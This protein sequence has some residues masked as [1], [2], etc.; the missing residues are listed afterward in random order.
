MLALA[1]DERFAAQIEAREDFYFFTRYLFLERRNFKW[2]RAPHHRILCDKLQSVLDGK[3]KRLI[4]NIPPRYSK[5][6]LLINFMAYGLGH[7]PD[8]EF[9]YTSY[10]SSL[11]T[12]STWEC[13]EI[14]A[15]PEFESIFPGV[16][17]NQD[18]KARD[19][20]RT[21]QTGLVYGVGAGGTITGYGA[22]K[23]RDGFG[24]AIVIDDPHKPDEARSDTIRNNVIEW[25][26]NTLE[27]RKNSPDTPV[28]LI[29]Q[30]LHEE[31]LSGFLLAGGNGETWEHLCL[32][33]ITEDGEALW[34]HKHD[35]ETLRTMRQASPY[36]FAG[37]YMQSPA[38]PE[39]NIFRPDQM[40]II[41][42]LPAG[43]NLSVRGWDLGSA[44]DGDY[45]VGAKIVKLPGGRYVIADIARFRRGPDERDT[46]MLNTAK[47][48]G[49]GTRIDLPQDPGQAGKS[50]VQYLVKMLKGFRV[51][52]SPE[53]GDK[54]TRAEPLAAQVNVGNVSLLSGDWNRGLIEEM[55]MF[56]NG[57]H[58][59][60]VDALSRAFNS[61]IGRGGL[62]ITD[63][64]L[65]QI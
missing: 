14:V 39:G 56:P 28:I 43:S 51:N 57:A 48:D 50:Q 1:N 58:D 24:G 27:S 34:E 49:H 55:R 17:I 8:S 20:W 40:P 65:R 25:F 52:T 62:S 33:A 35:I 45:T 11:A 31:D 44:L 47:L 18:A 32:P 26:R 63:E 23:L 37:Q 16:K 64:M 41:D 42:A 60:Q 38:P 46:A 13:R 36:T 3:I 59:D 19:E 9:I 30:R 15:H 7:A 5:T 2:Q 4:I 22:G 61:L 53:S 54:I 12:R 29:M 21:V 6:E 10:S